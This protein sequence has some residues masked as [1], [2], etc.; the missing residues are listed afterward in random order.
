MKRKTT[1]ELGQF[2]ALYHQFEYDPQQGSRTA[3][4][5]LVAF[6]G[7]QNDS[8]KERK[9]RERFQK[10]LVGRFEQL[11]GADENKLE[12]LQSLCSKIGI[13]PIPSTITACK[14]VCFGFDCTKTREHTD[15][16]A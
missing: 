9:A 14:K 7:W 4:N 5:H 3:Y 1:D 12:V 16:V 11:Y 2:F 13:S 15:S 10:A 6:F 8:N